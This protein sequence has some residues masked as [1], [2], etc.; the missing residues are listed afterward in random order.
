MFKG[1]PKTVVTKDGTTVLLRPLEKTDTEKLHAMLALIPEEEQWFLRENLTD[2]RLL[3]RWV[4]RLDFAYILPIIA[5]KEDDG[6]IIGFLRLYRS[7]SGCARHV[8][9]LRVTIHP[10]YRSQRVGSWMILDCAKLALEHG[11]EKLVAE[12][13]SDVEDVAIK[14]ARRLD[15]HH[16][17]II[18]DY[19]KDRRGNY[20]DLIIMVKTLYRDWSDF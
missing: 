11:I 20:N 7:P 4:E 12:F 18:K 19:V 16:E 8:A 3:Q 13:V 6:E 1:Y 14:A 15:F 17:A 9:H 5:V 10:E 2:A